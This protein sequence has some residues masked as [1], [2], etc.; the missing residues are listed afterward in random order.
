MPFDP[1]SITKEH[2][3]RAIKRIQKEQP[4][5][6]GS[7]RWLVI[8]EGKEYPPK[9][10]MRYAHEEMNGEH[11]WKYGGGEPTNKFLEQFGFK[12]I[13][14]FDHKKDPIKNLI[15]AYKSRIQQTHLKGEL[16]KWR[17]V[18]KYFGQPDINAEKF[19]DEVLRIQYDNL[20]YYSS[21]D[22]LRKISNYKPE[23]LRNAFQNLFL[24]NSN[25]SQ[26]IIDFDSITE[27]IFNE[28]SANETHSHQ[29]EERAIATYLTF[30]DPT[31]YTFYKD[32]FYKKFCKLLNTK[33]K[34]KNY[35]YEHYLELI[36]DLI[37]VYIKPDEELISLKEKFLDDECYPDP[38]HLILAQDILYQ[39]L[40]QAPEGTEE[41]SLTEN[42]NSMAKPLNQILYGPPGTGKTYHTVNLAIQIIEDKS[43]EELF[44]EAR[45]D[46]KIRFNEYVKSG[47]IVFCTFHQSTSYEDFVEGIKPQEP[48]NEGDNVIYKIEDGIF[49]MICSAAHSPQKSKNFEEAF[50]NLLK[51]FETLEGG[52]IELKTPR[53]NPFWIGLNKN[54][55]LN[56]FTG[57]KNKQGS[58]TRQNL[59]K[60][61]NGED[62]FIGWEGYANGIIEY[63][64]EK[65]GYQTTQKTK[66]EKYVF[67]IDE[68]NRGNVSQIFGELITLIEKD[69]R[70]GGRE[71]IE[72]TLPYS[73]SRFGVPSNLYIIGTMNTADRS[74]EALDTA[75]RRRFAFKEIEPNP[76]LIS[77][78]NLLKHFWWQN[79]DLQWEDDDW[80]LPEK[81]LLSLLNGKKLDDKAYKKLEDNF[82]IH[83]GV[84]SPFDGI[85]EFSGFKPDELL[86]TLNERIELLLDKDH[87]IGHAYFF[88][89]IGCS[90]CEQELQHIFYNKIIPLLEEYFYGDYSKIGLIL[91]K[92]FVVP[93]PGKDIRFADFKTEDMDIYKD[94]SLYQIIDYR[95]T[96]GDFIG[97]VRNIY[98]SEAEVSSNE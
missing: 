71:Q 87:K 32:S 38:N 22:A 54:N 27:K 52:K 49:K 57:N 96:G 33:P 67:I 77:P 15:E 60:H 18:K 14:K 64:K 11:I 78:K 35:K 76:E 8:I 20:I 50:N 75:L 13:N 62:A 19:D 36:E 1:K 26:R 58:F 46:L 65:H 61:V 85:V 10:V 94:K 24:G 6:K 83:D 93:K 66:N 79:I 97:A 25:L 3:Q 73:K 74:V 17:L 5:L 44:K 72:V 7:T 92:D 81:S 86:Y 80:I 88:S 69:K 30:Y 98:R 41:E 95:K 42:N 51:E 37:D 21:K 70:L 68:I 84:G 53:G 59:L 45:E 63:L 4:D 40:D 34:E 91:G 43:E 39:K 56:L 82:W 23:E 9:E 89:L 28:I 47:Q 31:T 2:I 55:N 29:Q 48:D 16:Y 12:I 90:D